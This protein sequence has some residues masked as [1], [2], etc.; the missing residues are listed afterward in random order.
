MT[1]KLDVEYW[2]EDVRKT[3][4][5]YE[6]WSQTTGTSTPEPVRNFIAALECY[7]TALEDQSTKLKRKLRRA[8]L[9][10]GAKR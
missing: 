3:G 5:E 1:L 6:R 7:N 8:H 10:K 9:S 2:A 4:E